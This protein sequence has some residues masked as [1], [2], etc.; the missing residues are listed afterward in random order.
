MRQTPMFSTARSPLH[1]KKAAFLICSTLLC[2]I[3]SGV[4]AQGAQT[5]DDAP[6]S[7]RIF[8]LKGVTDTYEANDIQTTI[9]NMIPREKVYYVVS[10]GA[11]A[12]MATPADMQ[13]TEKIIADI[14]KDKKVF[15]LTYIISRSSSGGAV[16]TEHDM[17]MLTNHGETV[18]K[19][20]V[21]VPL[22]TATGKGSD[23]QQSAVQYIDVG[24]MI[25][26]S[27][28]GVGTGLRLH[29]K[30]EQSSVSDEKSEIGLPD[31]E[32]RQVALD[33]RS[34]MEAGKTIPLGS[35]DVPGERVDISVK[36][37]AVP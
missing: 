29:T 31:P 34:G 20:G 23:G 17:V 37:E 9:R 26:A 25:R 12:V 4:L 35:L 27:L 13:R 11:L 14:D 8:P 18:L 32:I 3:P 30:I 6:E 33:E 1:A 16:K 19:R 24:L 28:E 22:L 36:V 2:V 21:R 5:V 15:R 10:E 7:F